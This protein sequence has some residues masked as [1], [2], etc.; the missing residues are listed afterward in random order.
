MKL[1]VGQNRRFLKKKQILKEKK[2]SCVGKFSY[3]GAEISAHQKNLEIGKLR[4]KLPSAS[5]N[6][7]FSLIPPKF[8]NFG[9]I[10]TKILRKKF[11]PACTKKGTSACTS[12]KR[13]KF[14]LFSKDLHVPPI[15]HK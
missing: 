6:N 4:S 7:I 15:H 14:T 11:S 8:D 3:V 5:Q 2:N 13:K 1:I 10:L 9:K 12:E